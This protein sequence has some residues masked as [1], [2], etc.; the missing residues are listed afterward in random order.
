LS[1]LPEKPNHL[2]PKPGGRVF[3][4]EHQEA[5]MT[6]MFAAQIEDQILANHKF[7]NR[8]VESVRT[9]DHAGWEKRSIVVSFTDGT[10]LGISGRDLVLH[11]FDMNPSDEQLFEA[12]SREE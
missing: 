2:P 1:N 12:A 8:K 5:L 6:D 11:E 9:V 4:E 3:H 10:A 7:L